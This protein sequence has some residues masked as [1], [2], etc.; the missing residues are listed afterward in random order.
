MLKAKQNFNFSNTV[1]A[2][3]TLKWLQGRI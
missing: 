2:L 3:T 1:T